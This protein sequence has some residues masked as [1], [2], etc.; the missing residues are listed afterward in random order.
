MRVTKAVAEVLAERHPE[1]YW[2]EVV[3]QMRGERRCERCGWALPRFDCPH[4]G[5]NGVGL[6]P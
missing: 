6:L 4:E 3:K 1:T 5:C 2:P